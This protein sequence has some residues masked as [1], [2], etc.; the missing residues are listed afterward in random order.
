MQQRGFRDAVL[1]TPIGYNPELFR[2]D[3]TL[4][5]QVRE[6]HGLTGFTVAY[7]GRVVPEK[8][9]EDLIMALAPLKDLS[10]QSLLTGSQ[11]TKI[12]FFKPLR[13]QLIRQIYATG[14]Y[15]STRR[16]LRCR[17]L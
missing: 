1:R 3:E 10:W 11:I 6:S 8:G 14:L 12:H 15:F 9:V 4:R 5:S 13:R 2:V 17:G 16:M 7:F